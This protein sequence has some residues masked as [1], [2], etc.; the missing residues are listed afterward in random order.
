MPKPKPQL[1]THALVAAIVV[2][3]QFPELC[4]AKTR[5]KYCN[6]TVCGNVT[7][8]YPFR[9]PTQPPNC[10]EPRFELDC[11]SNNRTVLFLNHG[12]FYVQTI[13]YE[14]STIRAIDPNLAV[15]DCSLPRGSL[16]FWDKMPYSWVFPLSL[17]YVVNCTKAI[18]S[19]LYI[20]ASRCPVNSSGSDPPPD[21]YVYFLGERTSPRDFDESCRIEAT[22]PVMVQNISG[23]STSDI[24]E[25][26]LK[27]GFELSWSFGSESQQASPIHALYLYFMSSNNRVGEAP[28][29]QIPAK[30][31]RIKTL[32]KRCGVTQCGNVNISHPFR[33]KTQ[34]PECGDRRFELDCEADNNKPTFFRRYNKFQVHEIF[35]ENSTLTVSYQNQVTD[36]CSLPPTG[37]FDEDFF[38][39]EKLLFPAWLID[40]EKLRDRYRLLYIV[41]C[42]SPVNSSIYVDADRCRNRSSDSFPTGSFFYFLDRDTTLPRDFDQSCTVVADWIPIKVKKN[43]TALSTAE[44]Y[45]KLSMGFELTWSNP[46]GQDLCSVKLSF[47]QIL[48]KGRDALID[49]LN[50]F[51]Y[52]II[53]RPL[54]SAF[55]G[56]PPETDKS[57]DKI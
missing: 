23:F 35:Y 38:F 13:W 52:Y 20:D 28:F 19:S 32:T 39:C 47:T 26:L 30:F 42:T 18:K 21:S 36:N 11:D 43:I 34:P 22:V 49:Y 8:S 5:N 7:I 15:D 3:L 53:H 50:S 56:F 10:G 44:V 33:L 51:T 45:E 6:S 1:P 57:R 31:L 41:N 40:D 46:Q 9:L 27:P 37:R 55:N 12:R 54:M 48:A 24:Y 4:V 17:M 25:K 14:Y 29:P 2:L 16:L